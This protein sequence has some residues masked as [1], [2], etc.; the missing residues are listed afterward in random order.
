M[1]PLAYIV[2]DSDGDENI[3]YEI[4]HCYDEKCDI[5]TPLF[6]K[7]APLSKDEIRA[8]FEAWWNPDAS[9]NKA[10]EKIDGNYKYSGTQY[11]WNVWQAAYQST[12]EDK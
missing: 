8:K 12:N 9:G 3:Y 11:A 7:T 10:T 6:A 4:P 2:K 5:L 1:N